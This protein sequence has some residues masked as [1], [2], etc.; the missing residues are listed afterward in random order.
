M[1]LRKTNSDTV[2]Y[3]QK[4]NK[5]TKKKLSD[6]DVIYKK[7]K[8]I[9]KEVKNFL[10]SMPFADVKKQTAN[11]IIEFLKTQ[12]LKEPHIDPQLYKSSIKKWSKEIYDEL[13]IKNKKTL[14][15]KEQKIVIKKHKKSRKKIQKELS[16]EKKSSSGKNSS[17]NKSSLDKL[18][19]S[20]MIIPDEWILPNKKSFIQW[21]DTT[22]S[23]YRLS[24][25]T[26]NS[27][28]GRNEDKDFS[29][30]PYQKLIRDYLNIKSPYRG[31]LLYHGLGSGKT[32]ASIGVAENL[33]Q[34]RSI[35]VMLPASL[36]SNF[37]GELKNC[38]DMRWRL[39][40][41]WKFIK[42]KSTEFDQIKG[43]WGVDLSKDKFIKKQKGVWL[44]SKKSKENY[45]SL[46]GI[47]KENINNQIDYF[48][49]MK[50]EFINY[51]GLQNRHLDS[52]EAEREN[53]FNNK[54]II[55]DEVHNLISRVVG[56]GTG[57]RLYNMLM[58]AENIRLVLLSGTPLINY[59]YESAFLLNLLRG[60]IFEFVIKINSDTKKNWVREITNLLKK[61][62][63]ID[64]IFIE[65][66]SKTISFTRNPQ[67]FSKDY[68]SFENVDK[69]D[70]IKT[71]VQKSEYPNN[72]S[73]LNSIEKGIK[74]QGFSIKSS[75]INNY[76]A[77]PQEEKEFNKLFIDSKSTA[78][79][80]QDLFIKRILGTISYYKGA[81]ADLFP[82]TSG[83]TPIY[84]P[85]SDFQFQ[86]Y[87]G[88]RQIERQ[89]ER[90]KKTNQ[91][92]NNDNNISSYYRVFSRAFG[93]FVF[94]ESIDRPLPGDKSKLEEDVDQEVMEVSGI[95]DNFELDQ[96]KP[97]KEKKNYFYEQAKEIALEN[98]EKQ[99][100]KYL[101]PGEKGLGKYSP[102]FQLMLE[103]INKSPGPV[104]VYSQFRSLEG[105]GIF[106]LVLKANGYAPFRLQKKSDGV[107]YI[108]EEPDEV[109]KPKYAFYSGT[110]DEEYKITI[111]NIYN[112]E[113][114][115]LTP[116]IRSF[117]EKRNKSGNLR[118]NIIKVL[119]ATA[120][121]AEGI[122]LANVRQVHITEPYWN[123]VRIE[124]VMGRAV[125]ICSHSQ[126][127]I[128]D[129]NVEVFLYIAVFTKKQITESFTIRS[130]DKSITTDQAI[131]E[132]AMRKQKITSELFR[133]MKESSIDCSLN[134]VENEPINC[135]SFGSRINPG[136]YSYIPN[137]NKEFIDNYSQETME[138]INA[139]KIRYPP[140][141]GEIYILN[142]DNNDIYSYESWQTSASRGGRPIVIGKL[143]NEGGK[144]II[145]FS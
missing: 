58:N 78:I 13:K 64:Q 85:M 47:E 32:C 25:D 130:K 81:R 51:N 2:I 121:A 69:I 7:S 36:R 82:K 45:G 6:D 95:E 62:N 21:L 53:P 68:G 18:D 44:P 143:L 93:N 15:K 63:S 74:A 122:S 100:Q 40:Q 87:E 23:K 29:L 123:P 101:I 115:K 96:E 59:P 145:K 14:K 30:F 89:K 22:Y 128:E 3:K 79:V 57:L 108:H 17:H 65:E 19:D 137:I 80:N 99:S 56:G 55:I 110:E 5:V 16:S 136:E 126:L 118:G 113:L 73:F 88:I 27:G 34:H 94:P 8:E 92:K 90:R 75:K 112:N 67:D 41:N 91:K 98:L 106:A 144:Q 72:N 120:S 109:G 1:S 71:P 37:I 10:E 70:F 124:Q 52:M 125:R 132:I 111:K 66:K 48:I 138:K 135:F 142:R 127:P 33:K 38:A 117:I 131:Y 97:K 102:K 9:Y 54:V 12:D 42:F 105:I 134:S 114:N 28:C 61:N 116:I 43:F 60:Y 139:V 4:S 39:N 133:L 107:W 86:K 49:N 77:L 140:K 76:L 104:F 119:L 129:R 84:V 46:S 141:T 103:N 20:D 35:V 24:G 11:K 50:Y 26:Q 31:L 83:I